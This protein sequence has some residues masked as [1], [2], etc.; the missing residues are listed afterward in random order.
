MRNMVE[1]VADFL[2]SPDV[3]IDER[4]GP[5]MY[6]TFLKDLLEMPHAYVD[7]SPTLL[8]R[9]QRQLD[10]LPD[11]AN[12]L[13]GQ[14]L[15]SPVPPV[16][17]LPPSP[18]PGQQMQP[19]PTSP[20]DSRMYDGRLGLHYGDQFGAQPFGAQNVDASELCSPPLPF[21]SE[22]LQSMQSLTSTPWSIV[23]PGE[24]I[25]KCS[26]LIRSDALL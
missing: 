9:G 16:E 13:S 4:H 7:H 25:C 11:S 8:K 3:A 23:M 6:S 5:K 19:S 24:R 20:Q 21:D 14:G 10:S 26:I 2:G 17:I 1:R 15:E 22:L 18:Q 12:S